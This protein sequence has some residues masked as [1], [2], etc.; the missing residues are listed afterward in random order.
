MMPIKLIEALSDLREQ[1]ALA[2]VQARLAAGEDP[3]KIVDETRQALAEVGRR[4]ETREYFIPE[5]VYSGE[6][7]RQ[8]VELVKPLLHGEDRTEAKPKVVMGTVAGDIHDIGKNIVT[9]MLD[10]N[11]FEV[12]DLGVDVPAEKFVERLRETGARIVGLSGLLTLAFRAMKGTI[13]TIRVAN[14][15][16]T[17]KI[18]IG[19]AQVDETIERYTGADGYGT[20]ALAAVRLAKAWAGGR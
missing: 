20:D 6:I 4:F 3:L 11:G 9:F 16:G 10:V 1:E 13:D 18:M 2:T 14:P 5:L 8:I 15:E 17:V 19:G 12:C 7:A